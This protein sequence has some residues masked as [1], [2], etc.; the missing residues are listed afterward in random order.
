[1]KKNILIS[2]IILSLLFAFNVSHAQVSVSLN[3]GVQPLWGPVGYDYVDYYYMP[4]YEVYYDVPHSQFVYF[5]GGHWLFAAKLPARYG[6]VDFYST[7]KV[8][9]NEHNAY[10]HFKEHQVKY[11]EYKHVQHKE[12]AIRDSK[13]PKYVEARNHHAENNS[14]QTQ[15][16][17]NKKTTPE[18]S[19]KT[20]S[21]DQAQPKNKGT[22][23]DKHHND[24][25]PHNE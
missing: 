23:K 25:Q 12:V 21:H 5:E 3:I 11:V 1:M 7:Y 2:A 20:K 19:D 18:H 22:E 6:R 9:I 4:Q 8:V 17:N 13:D 24:T 14:K 10:M 16:H 15:E